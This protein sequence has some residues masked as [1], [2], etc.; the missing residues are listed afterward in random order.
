MSVYHYT[1]INAVLNI[2]QDK[3]LRFHATFFKKFKG[4][5]YD[6][7]QPVGSKVVK[8]LC[9]LEG[10]PFSENDDIYQPC[11]ISFCRNGD[12]DYMWKNYAD[13]FRGAMLIIDLEEL[14]KCAEDNW[15]QHGDSFR[16]CS[17]QKEGEL[18]KNIKQYLMD[19]KD[20]KPKTDDLQ[21]D[22]TSLLGFVKVD[23]YSKEDEYR[24]VRP[25]PVICT[26]RYDESCEGNCNME[27]RPEPNKDRYYEDVSFPK[28]ALK[29]IQFGELTTL[30]E[31][32]TVKKHLERCGYILTCL[33]NGR[34]SLEID[35]V[36]ACD[37]DYLIT[38]KI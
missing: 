26:A 12:S 24:Y 3:E 14:K 7:I 36:N 21:N 34:V 33:G 2:I 17:Y 38:Q 15:M 37:F 5:D 25:Y 16:E 6:I 13:C 18:E 27:L 11:I 10:E 22:W 8:D 4:E 32:D 1:S 19:N 35:D 31:M 28:K 30:K 29:G 9:R 23:R 20:N